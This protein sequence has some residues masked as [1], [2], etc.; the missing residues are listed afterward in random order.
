VRV[1]YWLLILAVAA[2]LGIGM[3]ALR[4]P[5]H[6]LSAAVWNDSERR[7]VI[8]T[9]GYSK[10]WRLD[11]EAYKRFRDAAFAQAAEPTWMQC[12]K[13]DQRPEC[14]IID[15]IVPLEVW[16]PDGSDPNDMSNVQLQTK[17]VAAEKDIDENQA[18]ADFC[19]GGVPLAEVQ[20]R[21]KRTSR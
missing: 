1:F 11:G 10:T 15:H 21:F 13:D 8:C 7:D 12:H 16:S 17:S 14:L 20:A 18:R 9:H 2:L 19:Y 5:P 4:A 6:R 3:A